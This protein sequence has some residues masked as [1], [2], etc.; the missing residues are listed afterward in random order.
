MVTPVSNKTNWLNADYKKLK[1]VRKEI[2]SIYD[3]YIKEYSAIDKIAKEA[4]AKAIFST[5]ANVWKE[6]SELIKKRDA[7][8]ISK[9]SL[10]S[11]DEFMA[12]S[13]TLSKIGTGQNKYADRVMK[14]IEKNYRRKK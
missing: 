3:E 13:F 9:Y 4:E 2:I 6:A 7:V 5:D 8:L 10:T 14:V 11:A 1:S 12:E